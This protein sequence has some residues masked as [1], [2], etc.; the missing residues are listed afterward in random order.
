MGFERASILAA[1][2]QRRLLSILHTESRPVSVAE[3]SRRLAAAERGDASVVT[4]AD[5]RSIRRDLRHRSLPS[6]EAVGWIDRRPDGISL[7]EPLFEAAPISLAELGAPD[8]PAWE[9]VSAILARPYRRDVLT[10]VADHDGRLTVEELADELRS[11]DDVAWAAPDED[12]TLPITLHHAD[13]PK[14]AATGVLEY[15]R[16]A[17]TVGSTR[18]LRPCLDRLNL[19]TG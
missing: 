2:R 5:R 16:D 12:G 3:L 13:L 8:D 14:L 10:V 19:D 4:E 17:R 18:R 7:D 9:V 6:L 15:D 1:P 11:R